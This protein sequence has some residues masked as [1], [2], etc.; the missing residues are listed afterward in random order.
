[1]LL[2][3]TL[4]CLVACA[5]ARQLNS[6]T[7]QAKDLVTSDGMWSKGMTTSSGGNQILPLADEMIRSDIAYYAKKES[8]PVVVVLEV[9][10]NENSDEFTVRVI[11]E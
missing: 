9:N 10:E 11:H 4:T 1:M 5:A 7:V 8:A 6:A 3:L 2:R